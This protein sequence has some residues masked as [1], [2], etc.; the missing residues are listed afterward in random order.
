MEQS[1]LGA[2]VCSH[3]LELFFGVERHLL[4][5]ND[6]ALCTPRCRDRVSYVTDVRNGT[7]SVVPATTTI[8]HNFIVADFD[9]DGGMVDNDDGSSFYDIY[10]NFGVYGGAKMGNYDGH[11]KVH[12]DRSLCEVPV[13]CF[14]FSALAAVCCCWD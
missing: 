14:R 1:I 7:P 12:I 11:N 2:S 10:S 13:V 6:R 4:P 9:A 3:P 8:H 5:D